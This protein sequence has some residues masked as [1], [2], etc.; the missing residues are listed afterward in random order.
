VGQSPEEL[1]REIEQTRVGMSENLDAIGDRVSPGRIVER[2]RN[3]FRNSVYS[4]RERVMGV[5]SSVGSTLSERSPSMPSVGVGD[6]VSG[7]GEAL[8]SAPETARSTAQGNPL[9]AGTVAFGAGFVAAA[10]FKGTEA[11]AR[12]ASTLQ[13]KA[14]PLKEEA[15]S[16]AREVASSVQESGQQAAEQLKESATQSA[17]QVKQ[18]AQA[19]AEETKGAGTSAAEEVKNQA[20][21][22]AQQVKDQQSRP[23]P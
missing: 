6:R 23:T 20:S 21:G 4:V 1:R 22:S 9:L 18:T 17:E 10:V 2:R 19:K 14:E 13:E 8:R 16:I 5:P 11:E 7:A 3:R 15:T 12:A